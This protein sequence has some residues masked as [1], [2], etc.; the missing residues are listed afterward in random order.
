MTS[1]SQSSCETT[2]QACLCNDA[3]YTA[4]LQKCVVSSCTIKE[5]L[6]EFIVSSFIP[7][8]IT[9]NIHKLQ[10]MSQHR[11]AG[12]LYGTTPRLFLM[13]GLEVEL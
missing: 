1:V 2:D 11:R 13:Q 5:S 4:V 8:V 3:H 10:K 12:L 6:S 9:P 7:L